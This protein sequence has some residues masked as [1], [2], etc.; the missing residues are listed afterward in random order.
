MWSPK[1]V[2]AVWSQQFFLDVGS[3]YGRTTGA[4]WYD[5]GQNATITIN[6]TEVTK[7]GTRYRFAG[8]T[9]GFEGTADR[10]KV[11]MDRP[12]NVTAL[13]EPAVEGATADYTGL[14][15]GLA[16]AAAVALAALLVV[17]R[18]RTAGLAGSISYAAGPTAGF[19][20]GAG[21][22]PSPSGEYDSVGQ[23]GAGLAP[24]PQCGELLETGWA[25]C[26]NCGLELTWG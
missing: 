17:R 3:D 19:E 13:W 7:N 20:P 21:A 15:F 22:E 16:I 6:P 5:R 25:A 2:V 11:L 14:G 18:R 26:P 4:G 24:C 1:T 9:G 8:W 12:K 10:S 23:E